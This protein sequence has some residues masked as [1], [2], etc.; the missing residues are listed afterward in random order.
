MSKILDSTIVQLYFW[1][2]IFFQTFIFGDGII[3][4][5][6]FVCLFEII[7]TSAMLEFS[8]LVKFV[9]VAPWVSFFTYI[10]FLL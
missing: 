9:F 7:L 2:L 3:K 10:Y 8:H 6:L 5:Y 1:Q 4:S